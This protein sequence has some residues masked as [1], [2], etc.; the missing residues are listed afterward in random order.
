MNFHVFRLAMKIWNWFPNNFGTKWLA[1]YY[2]S[3]FA[4]AELVYIISLINIYDFSAM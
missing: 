4:V 3:A 2:S 1:A